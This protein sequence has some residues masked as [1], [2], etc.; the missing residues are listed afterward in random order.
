[1]ASYSN[2]RVLRVLEL[3]DFFEFF[4]SPN[5]TIFFL[6]FLHACLQL[7]HLSSLKSHPKHLERRLLKKNMHVFWATWVW[8]R[9]MSIILQGQKL[10]EDTAWWKETTEAIWS[11]WEADTCVK[12]WC[13]KAKC[14]TYIISIFELNSLNYR[15]I[16]KINFLSPGK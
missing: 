4:I 10:D 1:M 5:W 15:N 11:M 12:Y 16:A 13:G 2:I 8:S 7:H 6:Q 3:S 14:F 9:S